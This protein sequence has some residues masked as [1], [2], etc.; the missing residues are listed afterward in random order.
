MVVLR[1]FKEIWMEMGSLHLLTPTFPLMTTSIVTCGNKKQPPQL[2]FTLGL[3]RKGWK[4]AK[5][6]SKDKKGW[7]ETPQDRCYFFKISLSSKSNGPLKQKAE[8][9]CTCYTH[10]KQNW[11]LISMTLN[12]IQA[13]SPSLSDRSHIGPCQ[14]YQATG[15]PN[16]RLNSTSV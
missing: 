4:R 8:F 14:E 3:L 7:R 6:C 10:W 16:T 2:A 15:F 5:A 13:T 9:R 12:F 11:Q 1:G